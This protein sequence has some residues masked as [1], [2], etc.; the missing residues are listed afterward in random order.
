MRLCLSGLDTAPA[1][2]TSDPKNKDS[3]Q[4]R[5]P[6]DSTSVPQRQLRCH[7][8][9]QTFRLLLERAH[10]SFG[11]FYGSE[12]YQSTGAHPVRGRTLDAS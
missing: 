11:L 4:T 2:C 7:I 5:I 10:L 1:S 3:K 8:S 12:E 9:S 6:H